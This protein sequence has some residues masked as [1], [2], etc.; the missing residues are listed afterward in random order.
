MDKELG[1]RIKTKRKQERLSAEDLAVKLGA[2]AGTNI[3]KWEGGSIPEDPV[4]HQKLINWLDGIDNSH[5]KEPDI[6]AVLALQNTL[7][8]T[9]NRILA[10][11][12]DGIQS[13][14]EKIET[15]VEDSHTN[16]DRLVQGQQIGRAHL[17][18]LLQLSVV[19]LA[20]IQKRNPEDALKKANK[21]VDDNLKDMLGKDN[22][23]V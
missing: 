1:K 13:K 17:K 14:V 11:I 23:S 5:Q 16:L 8:Q 3:Y 12:K 7:L 22:L 9:Q 4:L 10:E 6:K 18:A 2:T 15:I 20:K 19:E 21:L